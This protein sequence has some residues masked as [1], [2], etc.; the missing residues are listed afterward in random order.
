MAI[1]FGH[2]TNF[3]NCVLAQGDTS[4]VLQ[5]VH[6]LLLRLRLMIPFADIMLVR[7]SFVKVVLIIMAMV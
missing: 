1:I 2:S 7:L 6:N 5:V 4:S 3:P